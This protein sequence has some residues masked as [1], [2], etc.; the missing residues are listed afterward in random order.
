MSVRALVLRAPGTNCDRE[1]VFAFERAGARADR[2]HVNRLLERPALLHDYQIL[3]L[4][5]GFCY[6]DDLGAGTILASRLRHHLGDALR[7][8]HEAGKLILGICNGFQALIKAGLLPG[9]ELAGT[10]TLA[11]NDSASF[12]DRWVHLQAEAGECVYLRG[13]ERLYLPVAHAE[14]KFACTDAGVL[15]RL[16]RQGQIVL[17][18]TSAENLGVPQARTARTTPLPYPENPNGSWGDVAGISD[19]SGRI[20]GLM[21]HPER[22][23]RRLQHPTATRGGD[24]EESSGLALFRNAIAYFE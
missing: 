1:T 15:T 3:C 17:R 21:P 24:L 2:L 20:F 19:P 11:P 9:G 13:V 18:Y 8:L 22:H 14:G 23:V 10:I 5:G 16:E 4:P 12:E 6:G 7:A